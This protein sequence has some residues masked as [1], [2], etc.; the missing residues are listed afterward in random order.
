MD[1]WTDEMVLT[2]PYIRILMLKNGLELSMRR[3]G[4]TA[5][6]EE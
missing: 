5:R 6:W 2:V 1:G 3:V 4:A